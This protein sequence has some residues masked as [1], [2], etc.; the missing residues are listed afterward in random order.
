MV[1][2][3]DAE[4]V[5]STMLGACMCP[6]V[7]EPAGPY[8]HTAATH[9]GMNELLEVARARGGG[10][11]SA[12]DLAQLGIESHGIHAMVVSGRLVRIRQGI[13]VDADTW[14][15]ADRHDRYRLFVRATVLKNRRPAVV[16]HLSAAAMHGLPIIGPWPT[17]V[18]LIDP[19]ASGGSHCRSVVRHRHVPQTAAI[20]IDGVAVAP[21][22]RTLIDV[23]ANSSFVVA[24]TM[25]DHVLH[26][27]R[28]RVISEGRRGRFHTPAVTRDGLLVELAEV[29]PRGWRKAEQAIAFSDPRADNPGESMSRV[30]IHQL[31]FQVPELQVPL[32]ASGHNYWVDFYWRHIG[33]IGEFDGKHKYTRG[34]VLGDRDPAQVVWEEKRREDALRARGGSF[35]RWDWDTAYSPALFHRFLSEH[36]VPRA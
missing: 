7:H 18:H 27:E 5:S 33:M 12:A 20:D 10:L 35:I 23:A 24:V 11:L 29:R 31:G 8:G 4:H 28:E 13:Y 22:L 15:T 1:A 25:I 21:L 2:W 26:R 17:A 9:L 30:H 14:R 32:V 34:A 3:A 19:D 16:S 36:E 6:T